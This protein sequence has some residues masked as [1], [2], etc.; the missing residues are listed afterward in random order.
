MRAYSSVNPPSS[1]AQVPARS[2]RV[3]LVVLLSLSLLTP[4]LIAGEQAVASAAESWTYYHCTDGTR[5]T[6]TDRWGNEQNLSKC[7]YADA[8]IYWKTGAITR[9]V[10]HYR[11][12]GATPDR[13]ECP[14]GDQ[15]H[16]VVFWDPRRVTVSDGVSALF[17]RSRPNFPWG[18]DKYWYC[19]KEPY[20]TFNYE[21]YHQSRDLRVR[22]Y[23][24][25]WATNSEESFCQSVL[26]KVTLDGA[27]GLDSGGYV[28]C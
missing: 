14:S 8:K 28:T 7:K 22:L 18:W 13:T 27:Q 23:F 17:S 3:I 10:T 21:V 2:F 4:L 9:K 6:Y 12:R 15:S 19:W 16:S 25:L 11:W 24:Y 20:K 5:S 26:Y 1:R